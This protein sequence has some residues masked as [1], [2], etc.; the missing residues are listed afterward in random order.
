MDQN[1]TIKC[2]TGFYIQVARASLGSFYD[3]SVLACGDI[4][5]TVD[6]NIVTKDQVGTEATRLVHFS[7]M[8]EQRNLGSVTVHLHHSSRTIQIQGSAVMP[9]S[10]RA[11]LWFLNNIILVRFKEQA[12]AKNFAVK[13]TNAAVLRSTP[14]SHPHS[15]ISAHSSNSCFSCNRGFNTQ[16]K[17][18]KCSS[19]KNFF[20]KTNCL[21]EHMKICHSSSLES[22]SGPSSRNLTLP[23]SETVQS[24]SNAP[25]VA[26]PS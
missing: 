19:C 26:A 9:D 13:S 16:S 22:D 6:K 21:K 14:G 18:S 15:T 7:F 20:H 24:P 11:A 1:A 12:K 2:S 17:P 4:A 23:S 10:T 25:T 3:H 5:I 8:S